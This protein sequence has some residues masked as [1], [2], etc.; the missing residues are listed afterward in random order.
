[1]KNTLPYI[2]QQLFDKT[3]LM[4]CSI[5]GLLQLFI[6]FSALSQSI[7]DSI[8]KKWLLTGYVET[9]FVSSKK[10]EAGGP[11]AAFLYNHNRNQ[12]LKINQAFLG[13]DYTGQQFRFQLALQ[14]GTYVQD[15]YSDEP[16]VLRPLLKCFAGIPLNKTKSSWLDAGIF[17]SYIGFEST[18]SFDNKTLT[19]SILA[20]NSP[21]YMTGLRLSHSA[22]KK[23][24]MAWYL[25]TGWQ[26]ISPIKGNSLPS[27]GWQWTYRA[28]DFS[29]VNWSFFAG[30]AQPDIDRK[31]RF[32]NNFYWQYERNKWFLT[33]GLD[34]GAEQQFKSSR[35][36]YFW[37]SPVIIGG[38]QWNSHWRTALRIEKYSDPNEVIARASSGMPVVTSGISLNVDYM[39]ISELLCRAEWKN[40]QGKHPIFPTSNSSINQ[41]NPFTVA[42]AW[43]W[44]KKL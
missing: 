7:V 43:R 26:R 5:I 15:N 35:D 20:E 8:P 33:A 9:Y 40:L 17:P 14:T 30:S 34:L 41:I 31:W 16:A 24:S 2:F 27:L 11:L 28:S 1:M 38:Y 6:V 32:F 29:A 23:L 3:Y 21:Y 39:P 4:R 10:T 25:L 22:G 37:W 36:Y 42:V 19:R 44:N 12:R 18:Q 13:A